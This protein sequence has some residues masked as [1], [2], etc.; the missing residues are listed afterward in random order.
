MTDNISKLEDADGVHATLGFEILFPT[1]LERARNLGI[2]ALPYD[3]PTTHKICAARDLKIER[4]IYTV[5][6]YKCNSKSILFD[7]EI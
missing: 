2:E 1:F 4:Y 5:V 6:R 7:F 3:D